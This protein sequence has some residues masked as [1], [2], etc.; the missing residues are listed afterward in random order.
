MADD[1]DRLAARL[2]LRQDLAIEDLLEMRV[3]VGGPFV[4]EIDGA[5]LQIGGEE[6][7]PLAL[8]LGEVERRELAVLH[9]DLA[10]ELQTGQ[11]VSHLP[12]SGFVDTDQVLEQVE[13][14][15]D[16]REH[17]AVAFTIL[18]RDRLAVEEEAAGVGDVKAGQDLGQRRFAAAVAAGD[19]DRLAGAEG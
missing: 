8:P 17:L 14:G 18:G 7:E 12:E 15:E 4:E 5:L 11:I 1:E 3:L 9:L 6:S 10:I 19:E 13:I 16:R 2:E